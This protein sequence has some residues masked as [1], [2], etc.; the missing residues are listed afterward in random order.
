M[1][2][3]DRSVSS[4]CRV[5]FVSG[6]NLD[7]G[8][9]KHMDM[10]QAV[11][12]RLAG[13]SFLLKGWAVT[14]TLG[15]LGFAIEK[16]DRGL[17]AAAFAPILIFGALDAYYL[18]TERLFRKLYD[19]VRKEDP[20]VAPFWMAATDRKFVAHVSPDNTM[21][22]ET[23]CSAT[24]L[25]FYLVLVLLTLAVVAVSGS[26]DHPHSA[27]KSSAIAARSTPSSS[28]FGG[29]M[30]PNSSPRYRGTTWRCRW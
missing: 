14:L 23:I 16:S 25:W 19:C 10:I 21:W 7:S 1:G 15:L 17:A 24:I 3:T 12:A 26:N 5:C 8:R 20:E 6:Y 4:E 2:G 30:L 13:N 18:R 27:R 28:C 9:I 22:K 29:Q 11:I